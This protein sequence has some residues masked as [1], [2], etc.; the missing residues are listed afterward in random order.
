[1]FREESYE[2]WN[3]EVVEDG[4]G[5]CES[6]GTT[7]IMHFAQRKAR[8]EAS[9]GSSSRRERLSFAV[10]F[11]EEHMAVDMRVVCQEM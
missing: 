9:D 2:D 1:M 10:F 5:L 8:V 4:F 7:N 3:D 6:V 11:V